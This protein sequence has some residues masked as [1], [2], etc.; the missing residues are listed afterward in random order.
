MERIKVP[1]IFKSS[2]GDGSLSRTITGLAL[3]LVT[4][5]ALYTPLTEVELIDLINQILMAAGAVYGVYGFVLKLYNKAT[6]EHK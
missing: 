6:G 3:A 4:I 2:K 5:V 1:E